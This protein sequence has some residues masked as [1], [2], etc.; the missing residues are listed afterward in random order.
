MVK[1]IYLFI[2]L[3]IIGLIQSHRTPMWHDEIYT[4]ANL[5]QYTYG[6]IIEGRLPEGCNEPLFYIIQKA[7]GDSRL[8]PIICMAL[9]IGLT[10]FAIYKSYGTKYAI[11]SVILFLLPRIT[12][13]HFAEC[14]PYSLIILLTTLL[15]IPKNIKWVGLIEILMAFTDTICLIPLGITLLFI[16][17]RE[18]YKNLWIVI[19]PSIVMGY[20]FYVSPYH[21]NPFSVPVLSN[22]YLITL[23][24]LGIFYLIYWLNKK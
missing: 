24:P 4:Q 16:I 23:L 1:S 12:W 15:F 8:F 11:L 3:V 2:A 10:F 19:I 22:R 17:R 6:Q 9:A 20:Y 21:A 18:Q 5:R 14:R 7:D 13:Q